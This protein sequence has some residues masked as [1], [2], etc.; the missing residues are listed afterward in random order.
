MHHLILFTALLLYAIVLLLVLR[1]FGL[2]LIQTLLSGVVTIAFVWGVLHL[3]YASDALYDAGLVAIPA[4]VAADAVPY[5]WLWRYIAC[6]GWIVGIACYVPVWF[7]AAFMRA[8]RQP[9]ESMQPSG[10]A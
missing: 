8:L 5:A 2:G 1:R 7:A 6:N 9:R 10:L 3:V 4:S